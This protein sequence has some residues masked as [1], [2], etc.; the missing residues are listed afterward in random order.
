LLEATQKSDRFGVPTSDIE[1]AGR[2]GELAAQI[3]SGQRRQR[4]DEKGNAP[5]PARQLGNDEQADD[6]S[7]DPSIR[8]ETFQNDEHATTM[9]SRSELA[10]ERCGDR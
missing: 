10:D 7:Q 2:L 4:A 6:S 3:R 1:I 5:T 8:P 9:A